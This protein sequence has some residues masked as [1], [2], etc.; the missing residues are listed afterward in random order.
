MCSYH[1]HSLANSL[2]VAHFRVGLAMVCT[3]FFFIA[4]VAGLLSHLEFHGIVSFN[5]LL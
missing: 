1:M 2:M 4:A 3:V 5:I